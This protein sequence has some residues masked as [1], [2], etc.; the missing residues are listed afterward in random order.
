MRAR[1]P[2]HS[3]PLHDFRFDELS[4]LLRRITP[5]FIAQRAESLLHIANGLSA[6]WGTGHGRSGAF[7]PQM[8]TCESTISKMSLLCL[9]LAFCNPCPRTLLLPISPT[10]QNRTTVWILEWRLVQ[11]CDT[12][13]VARPSRIALEYLRVVPRYNMI[14]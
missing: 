10:A 9:A 13:L 11:T 8:W 2:N 4:K 5:R 7:A 6:P 12:D 3:C 14:G 1:L